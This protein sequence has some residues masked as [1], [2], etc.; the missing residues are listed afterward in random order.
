[1]ISGDLVLIERQDVGGEFVI[2]GDKPQ[3]VGQK[4]TQEDDRS[5]PLR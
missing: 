4:S 5:V 2:F 3:Q 1:M